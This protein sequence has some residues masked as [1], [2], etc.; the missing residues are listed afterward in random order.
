[1]T[2]PTRLC[3]SRHQR[4]NGEYRDETGNTV[5]WSLLEWGG[6]IVRTPLALTAGDGG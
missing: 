3:R 2:M 6:E 5:Q 4:Q 1:M